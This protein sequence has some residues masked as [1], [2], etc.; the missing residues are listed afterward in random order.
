MVTT[1]VLGL[2]G[3]EEKG[4]NYCFSSPGLREFGELETG[5]SRTHV[6]T[7]VLLLCRGRSLRFPVSKWSISTPFQTRVT[8]WFVT[9]TGP[10][11][12]PS[13]QISW[14]LL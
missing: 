4:Q 7:T 12:A 6:S 10:P 1:V 11:S 8:F 5:P 9:P 2:Q 3:G 13:V 14:G